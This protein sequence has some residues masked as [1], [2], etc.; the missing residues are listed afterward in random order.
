MRWI[1]SLQTIVLCFGFTLLPQRK[2]EIRQ[3]VFRGPV[4]NRCFQ[5]VTLNSNPSDDDDSLAR[6]TKKEEQNAA[7][8]KETKMKLEAVERAIKEMPEE[9]HEVE[10]KLLMLVDEISKTKKQI[11]ATQNDDL[12]L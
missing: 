9:I 4:R 8:I 6:H 11:E 5:S 12:I 2:L 1:A 7:D 10:N 3:N